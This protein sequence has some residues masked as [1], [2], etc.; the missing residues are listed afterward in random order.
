MNKT[1]WL[2][3]VWTRNGYV[4]GTGSLT[5]A[6]KCAYYFVEHGDGACIKSCTGRIISITERRSDRPGAAARPR[7]TRVVDAGA[8]NPE[9]TG[10]PVFAPLEEGILSCTPPP[11]ID[12]GGP[13]PTTWPHIAHVHPNTLDEHGGE[14]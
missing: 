9:M 10:L 13:G 8:I 14:S 12:D 2:W 7:I 4:L 5:A 1:E 3:E 11:P 6:T